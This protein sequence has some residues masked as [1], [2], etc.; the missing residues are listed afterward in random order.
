MAGDLDVAIRCAR[1][2]ALWHPTSIRRAPIGSYFHYEDRRIRL[3]VSDQVGL[4]DFGVW[5]PAR[6]DD[7]TT[8][9][10]WSP[11]VAESK[12][13]QIFLPGDW[14]PYLRALAVCRSREWLD[15]RAAHWN[16]AH[17]EGF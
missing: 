12:R 5:A 11:Y 1:S 6:G 2:V 14:I 10:L 8:V 9:L 15:W 3:R 16:P 7:W 4:D 13:P 17:Y